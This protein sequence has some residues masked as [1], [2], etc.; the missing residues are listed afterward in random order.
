M[1]VFCRHGTR[2]CEQCAWA[3]SL[4]NSANVQQVSCPRKRREGGQFA[5]AL[6]HRRH[7]DSVARAGPRPPQLRKAL[8]GEGERRSLR[9]ASDIR[10]ADEDG[11]KEGEAEEEDIEEEKGEEEE[12]Q[13]MKE[14]EEDEEGREG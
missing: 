7:C 6:Q 2:V 13:E 9:P 8:W 5:A 11:D 4:V 3:T 12:Q 10:P 14:E 1:H